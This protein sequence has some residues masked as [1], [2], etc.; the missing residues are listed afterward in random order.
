[1]T[2]KQFQDSSFGAE[3]KAFLATPAGQALI[4]VGA[5]LQP[6]FP[7][8]E[9]PHLFAQAVGKREGFEQCIKN[10][11]A[12]SMAPKIQNEVE[13]NYGIQEKPKE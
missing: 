11:V 6:P 2:T 5:S 4:N 7:T 10:L 3:W 12:L 1:M 8:S 9:V 13:A